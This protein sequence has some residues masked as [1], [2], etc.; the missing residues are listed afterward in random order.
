[1]R[2]V[3]AGARILHI[4]RRFYF[5]AERNVAVCLDS[6][7][8]AGL[9]RFL[10][11]YEKPSR[12]ADHV[13][14]GLAVLAVAAAGTVIVGEVSRLARRR[15]EAK[16]APTPESIGEAASLATQDTV[17]VARQ[18][19]IEAPRHETVLFNMLSG[20]LGS[21]ATVRLLTW[22]IRNGRMPLGGDIVLGDTH[23]HHFVP[24]IVMAFG[25]GG[26]AL[27]TEDEKLEEALAFGFGAGAGLTFD[28]CALLLDLRDVYW[29]REG[30]LSVQISLAISALLSA[31]ILAM[32]MLRRGEQ[33]AEA[34][35]LIPHPGHASVAAGV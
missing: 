12:S 26:A 2:P 7:P 28:E 17:A 20:F 35:E 10:R 23:V 24:G 14:V 27:V 19:Y 9:S 18:A 31:S 1:M 15:R 3:Y 33:K 6:W 29:S 4:E 22:A 30:L 11:R 5:G 34:E 25:C 13:T 32:R 8:M 16:E 21:F